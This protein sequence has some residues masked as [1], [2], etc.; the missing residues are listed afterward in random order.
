MPR[1]ARKPRKFFPSQPKTDDANLPA[2]SAQSQSEQ[3]VAPSDHH[4]VRELS[5]KTDFTIYNDIS[6][7][8]E[9]SDEFGFGKVK[10]VKKVVVPLEIDS[11]VDDE[12]N[13]S[14]S[15]DDHAVKQEDDEDL[16]GTP[17]VSYIKDSEIKEP[18][19]G[20]PTSQPAPEPRLKKKVRK[21]RTSELLP[22][23]PTRR[24][25][26]PIRPQKKVPALNT[27]D[28]E[29][30]DDGPVKSK[31]FKKRQV[32]DKENDESKL[33]EDDLDSEEERQMEKRRKAVK[34]KFAEV[35]RWD[36]AFEAVDLSFS[37]Q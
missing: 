11:D 2:A 33:V 3:P 23:L 7:N 1:P 19:D 6:N 10:G 22:L 30:D 13:N 31:S 24:R 21:L 32:V 12:D 27:S 14:V 37:S 5:P 36:L 29:S 8:D 4:L 26:Q 25:R 15:D 18:G 16:Y 20:K 9:E 34:E 17:Y 35:D 28:A